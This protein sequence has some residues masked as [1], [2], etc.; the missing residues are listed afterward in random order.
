MGTCTSCW[1][2]C[3]SCEYVDIPDKV[4]W[5]EINKK[6]PRTWKI[7][8][9]LANNGASPNATK[10]NMQGLRDTIL[11]AVVRLGNFVIVDEVVTQG[12]TLELPSELY[13]STPIQHAIKTNRKDIIRFMVEMNLNMSF[14]HNGETTL[15]WLCKQKDYWHLFPEILTSVPKSEKQDRLC[16]TNDDDLNALQVCISERLIVPWNILHTF[17]YP[18][19]ATTARGSP[20]LHYA[21]EIAYD[22]AV[23]R[24]L[25]EGASIAGRDQLRRTPLLVAVIVRNANACHI[26][27]NFISTLTQGSRQARLN[28]FDRAG[29]TAVHYASVHSR[30]GILG[31]LL[32]HGCDPDVVNN[33]KVG[34]CFFCPQSH[35]H[36]FHIFNLVFNLLFFFFI[37]YFL[38]LKIV[39]KYTYCCI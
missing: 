2:P 21:V 19:D 31:V 27:L 25:E 20:T 16:G 18:I 24:L 22:E 36:I 14:I 34:C 3:A 28:D 39:I 1:E 37:L 11:H 32:Q 7:K 4:L 29:N 17:G 35:M 38:Y 10:R 13:D 15:T 8:R 6:R 30:G 5:K 12:A 33:D 23:E 9:L 26:L